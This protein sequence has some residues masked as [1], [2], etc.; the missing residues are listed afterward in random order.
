MLKTNRELQMKFILILILTFFS[1]TPAPLK[2]GD[3]YCGIRN[4]AWHSG[5]SINYHVYYTLAGIY[6]YGGEAN[7][8]VNMERY[9]GKPVYHIIGDGKTTSF[10]SCLASY[11]S[12]SSVKSNG[13]SLE[14][15]INHSFVWR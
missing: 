12:I 10:F 14:S 4:T 15:V 7:F 11:N 13:G 5:E 8:N 9:N 2:S 3:E 6:V 1:F